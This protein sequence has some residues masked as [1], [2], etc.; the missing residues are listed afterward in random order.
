MDFRI[1]GP[2]EVLEDGRDVAPA[3]NKL[4]ALLAVLL[5]HAN[6]TLTTERLVDELW[7]DYPPPNAARTVQVHVSRLR[8]VVGAGNGDD[9]GIVTRGRGYELRLYPERLD[10]HRFERLVTEGGG[11]LA[12]GAPESVASALESALSLWRGAPLADL[13]SEQFAQPESAR[14]DE[15]RVVAIE[16][17][18]EARLALGRHAEL[19]GQLEALVAEHPYRERLRGQ[20]MLAL[21][22]SERQA[23]AL[24]AYQDAR[25]TLVEELGIEPGE[26]LREL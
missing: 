26:W 18:N 3:G 1:L 8:K 17:L 5:L 7:A 19:V 22:R 24:Q 20:L 4:R 23:D 12:A 14:L 21:Y 2:L 6:E 15:L 13:A 9:G 25:V 11:D 16:Q 10:S